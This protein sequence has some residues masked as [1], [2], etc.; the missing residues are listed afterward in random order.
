[1]VRMWNYP[2]LKGH[3]SF[4]NKVAKNTKLGSGERYTFRNDA[5]VQGMNN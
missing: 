4:L 5:D 2:A 3:E 1:M